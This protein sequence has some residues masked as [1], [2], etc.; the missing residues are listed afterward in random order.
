[1]SRFDSINFYQNMPRIRLFLPKQQNFQALG[2]PTPVTA[3]PI[4]EF[5]LRAW[6]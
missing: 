2:A 6:L 3:L 5:S 1:M 4:A